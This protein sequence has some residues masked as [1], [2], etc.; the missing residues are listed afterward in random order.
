MQRKCWSFD[1]KKS[2]RAWIGKRPYI[3]KKYMCGHFLEQSWRPGNK[4][5]RQTNK[6]VWKETDHNPWWWPTPFND[7]SC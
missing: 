1:P 6:T 2:Q 5:M 3:Y 4:F 7:E